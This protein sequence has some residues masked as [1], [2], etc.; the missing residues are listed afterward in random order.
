MYIHIII[1]IYSNNLS[2]LWKCKEELC[3]Q[4]KYVFGTDTLLNKMLGSPFFVFVEYL[5]RHKK[6]YLRMW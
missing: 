2:K 1:L 6:P 3:A 4:L 5:S